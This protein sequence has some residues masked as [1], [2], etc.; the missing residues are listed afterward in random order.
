MPINL[1]RKNIL[2]SDWIIAGIVLLIF[3]A[4]NGYTYGWDDQHVEIPLL[5]SLIDPGLYVGDYYV[6]SL[7]TNFISCLYPILARIITIDQ[8]P[9]TYF[10]LYLLSR[11]F[12][13]FWIYK[14]WRAITGSR[15]T[16]FF[17]TLMIIMLGRVEEFLYRT[18]SHQELSLAIIFAGIYFFYKERF[19][20][21]A[22]IL[23]VAANFH[24][25]YSLF[26]FIYLCLYLLWHIKKYRLGII[27]K[28][29]AAFILCSLPLIVWVILKQQN[30]PPGD[31]VAFVEWIKIYLLACPQNFIFHDNPLADI[32]TKPAVFY[33]ATHFYWI[34]LGLFILNFFHNPVFRKDRKVMVIL[35]TGLVFLIFSFIFTYIFPNRFII[36]LNL[37]RHTQYMFFF[38]M[39]Y[40]LIFFIHIVTNKKWLPALLIA[41]LFPFLRFGHYI[42][43]AS[44]YAM[45]LLMFFYSS[46]KY[47]TFQTAENSLPEN[48]RSYD[49]RREEFSCNQQKKGNRPINIFLMTIIGILFL[50]CLTS[51]FIQFLLNQFSPVALTSLFSILSLLTIVFIIHFFTRN[52]EHLA[53]IKMVIIF[54]PFLVLLLDYIY[55]HRL[56]LRQE[57]TDTGFWQMQRNWLDMQS[58][59]KEN[60]PQDA[61]LLV[62]HDMPMGGFRIHSERKIVMSYRDCG[63]V[64]FDYDAAVEWH[65]RLND[66]GAFQIFVE[67]PIQPALTKAI[68]KYKVNYIV[69]MRYL[70]PG[71]NNLLKSLYKNEVFSLYA[72]T[73]NPI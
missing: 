46:G 29:C 23:G 11:Y 21:A 32:F 37:I 67:K 15:F 18:F 34:L 48:A 27:I 31:P 22:M 40:T 45:T 63:I 36:D 39:G 55:Y 26:P 52:P 38:L 17:A 64:G 70:D 30:A 16:G 50:L 60:V 3:L 61:L 43:V 7:K 8:I 72:V 66:I 6:E 25:L 56:H 9:L 1:N 19:V 12:L 59:V 73:S 71:E 41:L 58:Y 62:P 47:K 51:I 57:A 28:S 13:F 24:A 20:L 5:K 2:N 4:C 65:H 69:F 68:A 54:I 44:I 42:G 33:E 53:K 14:L 10:I 35:T 49:D